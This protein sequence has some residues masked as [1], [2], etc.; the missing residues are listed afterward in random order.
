[1]SLL[2]LLVLLA[3]VWIL[4]CAEMVCVLAPVLLGLQRAVQLSG[5]RG[6]GCGALSVRKAANG[7]SSSKRSNSS[8]RQ[9][10][11]TLRQQ[12][13]IFICERF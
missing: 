11:D 5:G 4:S 1:M 9:W 7:A 12:Q 13:Q 6:V 3:G 2:V 8:S 10:G